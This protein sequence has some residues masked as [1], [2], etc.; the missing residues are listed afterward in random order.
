VLRDIAQPSFAINPDHTSQVFVL[1][2][3]RVL[4]G[5]SRV[6]DGQMFVMQQD[7]KELAIDREDIESVEPSSQSIM[8]TGIPELLGPD[9]LRD[10]LTFLL[11]EPPHMP[12][13][14]ESDPPPP[15]SIDEVSAVL[16]AS[17]E[18]A[19]SKPLHLVLVSGTKDHG[20]GEHDY[21]AWQRAWQ[22]LLELDEHVRVTT[23]DLWP[24]A[25]DFQS[26]DV[27][28]FYQKGEWTAD[29]ARDIDAFLK[30]GGGLV[31]IHYAVDGGNDAPGF[32]QRIGLAWRGGQSKFRHG[33]L[34][35]QFA[36]GSH[37]PI[38]RNF[39]R[40]HFHDESYWNLVGNA[41]RIRLLATGIEENAPQP[42]F[43]TMEPGRGR[44]FVSIP[45]HFAWTFDDPLFRVLLLRG[46][47][48]AAGEPVD[49]FNALVTPGARIAQPSDTTSPSGRGRE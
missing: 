21:P 44:V 15:R 33:P 30:R 40:I 13:Y 32:A 11:I 7:A 45:G 20:P 37:H 24:T 26:A 34:D 1:A 38:A 8:P 2:S 31:Y 4:T 27:L 22:Q 28:V 3:G 16:V 41:Q 29:R 5:T 14:G 17:A 12:V 46:I 19:K 43:W 36:G 49:R 47:A 9:R 39:D 18:I 42:L 10:L 25:D 48:W 23:A 6:V 35:V